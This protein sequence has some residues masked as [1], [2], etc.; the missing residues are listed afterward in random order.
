VVLDLIE[1]PRWTRLV[2]AFVKRRELGSV[3]LTTLPR[4]NRAMD[5]LWA[6]YQTVVAD[7]A[8]IARAR[9][10]VPMVNDPA[11]R[12]FLD[13]VL[14]PPVLDYVWQVDKLLRDP[15]V[16]VSADEV[17]WSYALYVSEHTIYGRD[18][19]YETDVVGSGLARSLSRV[20]GAPTC[21]PGVDQPDD[22]FLLQVDLGEQLRDSL[23]DPEARRFM[24]S[25]GL[26]PDGL[27]QLFHTTTGDSTTEPHRLGGGATVIYLTEDQLR[28]RIAPRVDGECVVFPAR[29]AKLTVLPSF[30]WRHE[31]NDDA[32]DKITRLQHAVERL[33]RGEESSPLTG[34]PHA[35]SHLSRP[36]LPSTR[37]LGTSDHDY[38]LEPHDAAQL[39]ATLP[40]SGDGDEHVLLLTV[41]SEFALDSVYG[42]GGILEIWMRRSDLKRA[43]FD[44]I[45][46][47]SRTS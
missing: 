13:E 46:C 23:A 11:A 45:F 16:D 22:A 43:R 44:A 25:S 27:L 18:D 8:L 7:A 32:V 28:R 26:P 40:L 3:E 33:A 9:S 36:V 34:S 1:D 14:E 5:A 4:W 29:D 24:K 2:G 35:G 38:P 30:A 15:R 10:L 12:E 20:G 37:L 42:D 19:P 21:V 39:E 6:A 47:L 17:D 41:R 31:D